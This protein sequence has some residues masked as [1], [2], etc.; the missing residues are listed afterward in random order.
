MAKH[1]IKWND[2][3]KLILNAIFNEGHNKLFV[4][5]GVRSGKSVCML[6]II[7][8]ICR[9]TP[10]MT[11][12]VVRKNYESIKTDTHII[13]KSNPG[14]LDQTKGEWK[15][16]S[17]Q[18]NYHNGST[19]YFRHGEGAEHLLGFTLGGIY[20]EQAETISKEDYQLMTTRLSQWGGNNLITQTYNRNYGEYVKQKKL[21]PCKNYLFLTANPKPCWLKN[22]FIDNNVE[23]FKTI[24]LQTNDNITNL[25]REEIEFASGQSELFRNRY[26]LGSWEFASGLIYPEFTDENIVDTDFELKLKMNEMKQYMMIDPGYATS[27][28]VVLF[29]CVLPNGN[30]YVYDEIVKN[31]K[32][33][34]EM[35]KV[36][37]P[38]IA[39]WIKEKWKKY[40]ILP[41]RQIID[42]SANAKIAGMTSITNTF[43]Q[44]GISLQN[45]NKNSEFDVIMRIKQLLKEKRLLVNS[46]CTW[47]I[48]EFGL[49]SWHEKIV[50]KPKDADNDCMDAIRYFIADFPVPTIIKEK[51]IMSKKELVNAYYKDLFDDRNKMGVQK[52]NEMTGWGNDFYGI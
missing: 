23:G 33:E 19:I 14:I 28:F 13:L 35:N 38:E 36:G 10:G 44:F 16:G 20:I 27:K 21:L 31:G 5:G 37:I 47:T 40:G 43:Q 51:V 9:N 1:T 11:F 42:Y 29:G 46:R 8:F 4:H 49:F 2:K 32:D 3:Q 30:L 34:E 22:M 6:Y 12:L 48:R 50:D 24:H 7:D 25:S 45:A 52:E 15:D 17:R 18:F 41:D 39:G 26:Y